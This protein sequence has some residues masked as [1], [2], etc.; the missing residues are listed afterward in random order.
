MF[1]L[2]LNVPGQ[3]A[4]DPTWA[5]NVSLLHMKF[6]VSKFIFNSLWA[7]VSK[8]TQFFPA[9]D[10]SNI[11]SLK[12]TRRGVAVSCAAD[13]LV[14]SLSGETGQIEI[15][16]S[17]NAPAAHGQAAQH[18]FYPYKPMA[19]DIASS[20]DMLMPFQGFPDKAGYY[21]ASM[22]PHQPHL[23]RNALANQQAVA[24]KNYTQQKP[25]V[26]HTPYSQAS[27]HS[28]FEMN[29]YGIP[30]DRFFTDF[31][32][33]FASDSVSH[34]SSIESYDSPLDD[35]FVN[36][37]FNNGAETAI[38]RKRK[39]FSP[40]PTSDNMPLYNETLTKKHK[41]DPMHHA[42]FSKPPVFCP[43]IGV[44]K[45]EQVPVPTLFNQLNDILGNEY[46][47][48]NDEDEEAKYV[49]D[50][51]SAAF[52]VKSY[53]TRHLRKHNNAK[54]F[55]CPFYE[56]LDA[57]YLGSGRAGTKCHSTGGF[58]RKDTYKTHLKALHFIYP[59]RTRSSERSTIGGRCAGCFEHFENNASWFKHHIEMAR[60][61]GFVNNASAKNRQGQD[62]GIKTEDVN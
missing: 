37:S 33:S 8:K 21:P 57:D 24:P 27:P 3:A 46:G 12:N 50:S 23:S 54:A 34:D 51:C 25:Q 7:L 18:D 41:A 58:S 17:Y 14:L 38:P 39:G 4:H 11:H 29:A 56:E 44:M 20:F 53:L 31:R 42:S 1:C 6:S 62:S 48:A 26:S 5:I 2:G 49:C 16:D 55:V 36:R 60:C 19:H 40:S 45:Q 43:P 52:K 30:N 13:D 47:V 28:H 15:F 59:P 22:P 10:T 35:L 9:I 61:R 32:R